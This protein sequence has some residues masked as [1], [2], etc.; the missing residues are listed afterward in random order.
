M[1]NP[2]DVKGLALGDAF[3]CALITDGTVRCWGDGSM[4]QMGDGLNLNLGT[5]HTLPESHYRPTPVPNLTG[6]TQIVAAGDYACAR[7]GS[8]AVKCWGNGSNDME[9]WGL[10]AGNTIPI[11]GERHQRPHQH[12]GRRASWLRSLLG[13]HGQVLGI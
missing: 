3:A 7:L 4:G 11:Y 5:G 2:P 12:R 9:S 8:G 6:V 13:E 10:L 1:T